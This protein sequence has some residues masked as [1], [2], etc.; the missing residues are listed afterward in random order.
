MLEDIVLLE[1]E[2]VLGERYKVCKLQFASGEFDMLIYDPRENDCAAFEIKHSRQAVPAQARH[3]RDKEKLAL[4]QRRFGELVGRY[5]LYLG[6]N[7]DMEDGILYRNAE[8]FLE[9]L[10]QISLL[11]G[12]AVLPAIQMDEDEAPKPQMTM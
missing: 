9:M 5:V 1:T 3:L 6:E 8:R 12:L 4:T 7:M 10:P 11:P 2:K